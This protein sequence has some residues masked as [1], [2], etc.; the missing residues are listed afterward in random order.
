M[1]RTSTYWFQPNVWLTMSCCACRQL[2]VRLCTLQQQDQTRTWPK[3][4]W[5]QEERYPLTLVDF[6][7]GLYRIL[8]EPSGLFV[9]FLLRFFSCLCTSGEKCIQ[10]QGVSL[11]EALPLQNSVWPWNCWKQCTE[12]EKELKSKP[13]STQWTYVMGKG[14][15]KNDMLKLSS[16]ALC[17]FSSD[18]NAIFDLQLT[19]PL[20][21]K[22]YSIWF[23][24]YP[25]Q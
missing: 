2:S 25:K 13:S 15:C 22:S 4:T 19:W 5:N 23:R 18:F 24:V 11:P 16:S 6:G 7:S 21:M 20:N 12:A 14:C 3:S 9:F 8:F 17:L 1:D 10:K